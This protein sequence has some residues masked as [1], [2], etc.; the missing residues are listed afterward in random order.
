MLALGT[1]MRAA[2]CDKVNGWLALARCS[3]RRSTRKPRASSP[4]LAAA[5]AATLAATAPPAELSSSASTG[6]F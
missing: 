1:C 6:R 2:S 5:L 4:W 3:I